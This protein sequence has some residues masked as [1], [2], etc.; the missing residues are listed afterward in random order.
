MALANV[1]N[2]RTASVESANYFFD[3]NIWIYAL[4]G[5][6]LKY[7]WQERY[8]DFFYSVAESALDPRPR[9]LMPTLLFSEILHTWLFKISL[10]EF[11]TLNQIRENQRFDVKKDYRPTQ[12]Y[13]DNY[14]R[15]CDD[16][17]SQGSVIRFIDD[18]PLIKGQPAYLQPGVGPFDLNDYLY[19]LLCRDFQQHERVVMVSHDG[20]FK[21]ATDL[22]IVTLNRELLT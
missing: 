10:P 12:H 11:K 8:V 14:E 4:Q 1:R 16:I 18:S 7:W 22:S 2:L 19:Y 20:D 9:I 15:I 13:R 3:A 5:T 21:A 6:A 17:R